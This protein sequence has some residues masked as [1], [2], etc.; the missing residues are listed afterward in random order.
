MSLSL[1]RGVNSEASDL[2]SSPLTRKLISEPVFP[3]N[4]LSHS[5]VELP[6]ELVGDR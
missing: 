3:K 2:A 1:K 6:E 4:G 5:L